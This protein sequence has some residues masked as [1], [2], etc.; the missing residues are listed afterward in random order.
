[1]LTLK[2]LVREKLK[3]SGLIQEMGLIFVG[4]I[5]TMKCLIKPL[6][7]NRRLDWRISQV[8]VEASLHTTVNGEDVV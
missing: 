7:S 6:P 4:A 1:M 5:R 2:K 3:R 8:E